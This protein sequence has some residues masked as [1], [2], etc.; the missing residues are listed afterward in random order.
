MTTLSQKSK[1]QRLKKELHLLQ[2]NGTTVWEDFRR[3]NKAFYKHIAEIYFWWLKAKEIEGYLEGEYVKLNRRF[4][5]RI[6]T[7]INFA[8]V[9]TLTWGNNSCS[10]DDLNRHSRA[11]NKINEEY[12]KRKKY[13]AKDGVIKIAAYI[14]ANN[15]ING[16]TGYG[17]KTAENEDEERITLKKQTATEKQKQDALLISAISHYSTTTLAPLFHFNTHLPITDNKLSV[18]LVRQTASGYELLGATNDRQVVEAAAIINFKHK[19]SAI[20]P[21][22]RALIELLRTQSLPAHLQKLQR[23]LV[24]KSAQ[25]NSDGKNMLSMR[26]VIYRADTKDFL[27]SPIRADAGVVSVAKLKLGGLEEIAG[28]AFLS[29]YARVAL[30][31]LAIST[32]EF[33]LYVAEQDN[34]IAKYQPESSASHVI[35]L[36]SLA[37]EL[38]YLNLDFWQYDNVDHKPVPQVDID[39]LIDADWTY[40]TTNSWFRE[41][42]LNIVKPWLLSHGKHIK[43][44]H[45]MICKL[46]FTSTEIKFSF[47]QGETNFD[48]THLVYLSQPAITNVNLNLLFLTKD[49]MPV[50]SSIA[51]FEVIG[52]IKMAVDMSKIIFEFETSAAAFH[53]AVPTVNQR[54]VRSTSSFTKYIPTT[55]SSLRVEDTEE[56]FDYEAEAAQIASEQK[57]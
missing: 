27:L 12:L 1:M 22:V 28:D 33:N 13:Y 53:L 54:A 56:E 11:L 52:D 39:L 25:K 20:R 38:D 3:S 31:R 10:D 4:K 30:E 18:V 19:F 8:P 6:S 26:R 43:R 16:L 47:V 51:D 57:R 35:R 32:Y 40:T 46:E 21:S 24:D 9:L 17:T 34:E 44:K 14:E 55:K 41:L 29:T 50:L 5:R 7:G 49:L 36:Q 15:G 45:Q 2:I 42:S 23:D 37:S 48:H